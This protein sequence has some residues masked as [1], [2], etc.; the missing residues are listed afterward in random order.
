MAASSAR[1]SRS[2]SSRW[3]S[4]RPGAPRPG[5]GDRGSR[6]LAVLEV[7]GGPCVRTS[8]GREF[9][10]VNVENAAYPLGICAEKSAIGAAVVA[11]YGAGDLAAIGDHRLAVR[12]LPP[13]A[14]RVP[15]RPRRLPQSRRNVATDDAG[16]A[17]ARWTF[18]D[19]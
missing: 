15:H 13:V 19:L 7:P 8:D 9:E 16:G 14:R 1:S 11:G 18:D 2:P 3:R 17:P 5:H 10:G 6:L 4:D 12:R